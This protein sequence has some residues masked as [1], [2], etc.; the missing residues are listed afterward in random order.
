MVDITLAEFNGAV[1]LVGGE[2]HI[3]NLLANTLGPDVTIELV[4]CETKMQVHE[5]WHKFCGPPEFEGDPWLIHPGI[6]NRIRGTLGGFRVRFAPWSAQLDAS[7]QAVIAAAAA[8]AGEAGLLVTDYVDAGAADME[9]D[10]ARL[11]LGLIERALAGAG[12]AAGRVRRA[13]L[14]VGQDGDG[15]RVD[16]EVVREE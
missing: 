3:D 9:A 2:V 14:P 11:R 8:Q 15:E 1:W 12:V 10:L 13:R 5:L 4:T 6:V 7:A 16:I